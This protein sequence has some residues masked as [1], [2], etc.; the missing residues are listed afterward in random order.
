VDPTIAT[1]GKGPFMRRIALCAVII[2]VLSLVGLAPASAMRPTITRSGETVVDLHFPA[3]SVCPFP[4][5]VH[6]VLKTR[7]IEFVD[8]NGDVVRAISTGKIHDWETNAATGYT[9][10]HSIS[11][12]SFFDATGALIRGTGAWSGVQLQD[13]TW[14]R[15]HGLITFDENLLLETVRGRVEPLC[16]SLA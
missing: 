15:T 2:T 6:Q 7:Y 14:V 1:E 5:D 10:F 13:G 4:V 12:P 3:G 16:D 11:G 8:R 9:E